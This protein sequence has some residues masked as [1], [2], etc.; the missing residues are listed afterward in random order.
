MRRSRPTSAFSSSLA[1][2]P[3]TCRAW[4]RTAPARPS[5]STSKPASAYSTDGPDHP[6]TYLHRP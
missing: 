2:L 1:T 6:T 4:I 5:S 3:P